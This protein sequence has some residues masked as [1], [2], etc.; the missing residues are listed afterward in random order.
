MSARLVAK[1]DGVHSLQDDLESAIYVLLWMILMYSET[2]DRDRVPTFLSGVLDPEP[3]KE[4]GGF[5][6]A[7]FLKARTFLQNVHFPNR[8]ALHNL[9]SQLAELFAVR[10]EEKPSEVE[11]KVAN[12]LKDDPALAEA[13]KRT[14]YFSYWARMTALENHQHTIKL[15][16]EALKS[17]SWLVNDFAVKQEFGT[18]TSLHRPVTKTGWD[19]SFFVHE[20]DDNV[21]EMDDETGVARMSQS[22]T[23]CSEWSDQMTVAGDDEVSSSLLSEICNSYF[24]FRWIS[25]E[26]FRQSYHLPNSNI[27]QPSMDDYI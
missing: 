17:T 15:F 18:R 6:K 27:Q 11:E 7:D 25:S 1:M 13:Y 5:N 2:S 16:E 26:S 19:T 10:Y 24:M 9:I 4:T 21:F 12:T 20:M 14:V 23:S 8:E 3:H 22:D